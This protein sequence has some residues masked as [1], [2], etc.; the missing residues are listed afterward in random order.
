M[1]IKS[2]NH[3]STEFEESELCSYHQVTKEMLQFTGV[4]EYAMVLLQI[5]LLYYCPL[6]R[7]KGDKV[8][9]AESDI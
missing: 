4:Q 9:I 6:Q 1:M 5:I 8:Q 7:M 2:Y 3:L